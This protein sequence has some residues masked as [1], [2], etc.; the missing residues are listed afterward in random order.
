MEGHTGLQILLQL[1]LIALNAVFACA[2]IAVISINDVKL[3][4]MAAEANRRAVRLAA[5]TS[6]PARFLATIQ[7]AITLSGFLGSAFAADNFSDYLTNWLIGLGVGI[8]AATLDTISVIVITIVLSYFTLVFGELVPK[9]AA[10][11]NAER[12]ALGM[13]GFITFISKLFAPIVWVLTAS[14][15]GILRL[16]RIDPD[17]DREEVTEEEI[18]MMVDAGSENGAIDPAERELI[19]N[20]FEFDDLSA[21]EICTHRTE[22]DLLWTD[23]ADGDWEKAIH[24]SRH[25]IYPVCDGSADNVVGILDVRDYFRLA[26]RSRAAVMRSAV[27]PPFFVPFS[28]KADVLF[29]NMREERERF[30]VVL[31]EYGGMM[32]VVTLTDLVERLVGDMDDSREPP[33]EAIR[34]LEGGLWEVTGNVSLDELEDA[35]G[36]RLPETGCDTLGGLVFG[37][38]GEIPDDG[39]TLEL[40][41]AGL[42]IRV[43]EIKGHRLARSLVSRV[44]QPPEAEEARA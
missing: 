25:T 9:R 4:K 40:T 35:M 42:N 33:H 11:K 3:A 21:G 10:M 27:Y 19:A 18:L 16:L 44:P 41:A 24:E 1:F 32:G 5:L 13:S 17:A 7:V 31:D 30:A 34:R 23:D 15:N 43:L 14:T 22:V 29:R 8:P 37:E 28:V 6:R 26:D 2:E 20:V 39:D 36:C 12:L 38:L